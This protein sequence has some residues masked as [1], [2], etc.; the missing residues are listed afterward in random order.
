LQAGDEIV[1]LN[2]ISTDHLSHTTVCRIVCRRTSAKVVLRRVAGAADNLDAHIQQATDSVGLVRPN[3]AK[4]FREKRRM[5]HN[6]L[7]SLTEQAPPADSGPL[8]GGLY[9]APPKPPR[10]QPSSLDR[11]DQI[12]PAPRQP[13]RERTELPLELPR[14]GLGHESRVPP[15]ASPNLQDR[16]LQRPQQQ[17]PATTGHRNAT[18]TTPSRSAREGDGRILVIPG[19]PANRSAL[20]PVVVAPL[21]VSTE[22]VTGQQPPQPPVE[23]QQPQQQG[24]QKE[25]G[26]QQQ[27]QQQQ[28]PQ[29]QGRQKEE[30]EQ[31]Q[32]QQQ[33]PPQQQGRQ[34]EEA[35]QQY[36]EN[37][38]QRLRTQQQQQQQQQQQPSQQRE[39][40]EAALVRTANASQARRASKSS[41]ADT[42][43]AVSRDVPVAAV[44]LGEGGD[45]GPNLAAA[46]HQ[47]LRD[48]V[49]P[50]PQPVEAEALAALQRARET[51]KAAE[52]RT[53]HPHLGSQSAP[54]AEPLAASASTSLDGA[55]GI[56]I[57]GLRLLDGVTSTDAHGATTG[58]EAAV[59]LAQTIPDI[60]DTAVVAAMPLPTRA[61]CAGPRT[62]SLSRVDDS[63]GFTLMGSVDTSRQPSE[64][65]GC[66]VVLV[67]SPHARAAGLEVGDRLLSVA[68][69]DVSG[70]TVNAVQRLLAAAGDAVDV[71]VAQSAA[72]ASAMAVEMGLGRRLA[73]AVTLSGIATYGL[74][75]TVVG[76]S[77][78][79]PLFVA[80]VHEDGM[81]SRQALI[82]VG[83]QIIAVDNI[84]TTLVSN[85]AL[86][87]TAPPASAPT[88]RSVSGGRAFAGMCALAH[89]RSK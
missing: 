52:V 13:V 70:A 86:P 78:P 60:H 55:V 26:E 45:V 1:E 89:K 34:E 62:L 57:S 85:G 17:Q 40:E 35:G 19:A 87:L 21:T 82:R 72:A 64:P 38:H 53:L 63:L 7:L 58:T 15:A 46:Q 56:P 67:D 59:T 12:V 3:L 4:E 14:N 36:M 61:I 25:E 23:Q 69:Q 49:Q 10:G 9:T 33:Q 77:T 80:E 71:V 42:S 47:R 30:G 22:V 2:G 20:L 48:R 75:L 44:A 31:Q 6:D 51:E 27:Q 68:G 66:Y 84:D 76:S 50:P 37:R 88:I 41:L 5:K 73:R 79:G 43:P 29:Q 54:T 74:G 83:D 18:S 11:S 32:Q 65:D 8:P 39:L 81:L 24:R 16:R 28:Q